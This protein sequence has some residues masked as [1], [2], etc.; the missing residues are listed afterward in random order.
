MNIH[1]GDMVILESIQNKMLLKAKISDK[2]PEG[3]VF[4]SEDYEWYH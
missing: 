1:N 2:L 4:V 3:M